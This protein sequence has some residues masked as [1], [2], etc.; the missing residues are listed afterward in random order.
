MIPS[1]REIKQE[2]LRRVMTEP[3]KYYVP[4]GVS[5]KYVNAVFSDDYF[6]SLYSAAN[7]VGKTCLTANMLANLFWP[8]GNPFFQ[9]KLMRNW[10]Y[11]KRGRIVSEPTTI[12]S[13]IIPEL[14]LWF[15]AGRYETQKMSKSY[16]YRWTTDTGWQFDIMSYDQDPKEFES[17][18]LGFI[19][20][21]EPPPEVIYKACVSRLRRG[22]IMF[23]GATP[24]TGSA[25]MYDQIISNPDHDTGRR[26]Y[27]EAGV[28]SACEEHG[29]RG[30]L[31]HKHIENMISQYSEEEKQ[32]RI[33][34]RFQHLVGL[35]YKQWNR[36]VHV[37]RPFNVNF[38]DYT[39]YQALDP[40]PRTPDTVVWIAVD[41]YGQKFIVDELYLK[42]Q[43]GSKELAERIWKKDQQYR[44][45]RRV[46]DPS[47]FIE[48]QHTN[49]SLITRLEEFYPFNYIEASKAR[50]ASDRRIA[51][52]LDYQKLGEEYIETPELYI[53]DNCNRVI[54]EFEHYRWDEWTGK[55]VDKHNQKQKP[56]DK[57]DH[58]IECIGRI[59][60]QEPQW[61]PWISE[62]ELSRD[63]LDDDGV[64]GSDDP[65]DRA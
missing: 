26:F 41:K 14:K 16:E 53:F 18:N 46:A 11:L 39:V 49:K 63:D 23:I 9:Q 45:K 44:V 65:F 21:D 8:V 40:H 4:T 38:K 51:D 5:E 62:R 7:G 55:S 30:F 24:L 20:L 35:V 27:I 13:T 34:G 56:V 32:A 17:A 60:I 42:C 12:T 47:A 50:T 57:D 31:K 2:K 19:A 48:D 1:D 64:F 52:A 6:I 43:G 33:H 54:W 10:P 15:P 28:E 25:W 29:E 36:S 59:L 22:G 37:I 3:H 58:T 61:E